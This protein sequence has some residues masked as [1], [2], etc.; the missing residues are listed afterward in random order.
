[1]PKPVKEEIIIEDIK[2]EETKPEE[3]PKPEEPN[4]INDLR[5]P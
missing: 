1:M 3:A 2:E 5:N 4:A